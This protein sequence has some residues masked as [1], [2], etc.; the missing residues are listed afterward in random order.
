M[1]K[2]IE[3]FKAADADGNIYTIELYQEYKTIKT[4]S[5]NTQL[6]PGMQHYSCGL[7]TVSPSGGQTFQIMEIDTEVKKIN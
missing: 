5:G 6:I 1:N 7:Y 4:L 2:L 3:S